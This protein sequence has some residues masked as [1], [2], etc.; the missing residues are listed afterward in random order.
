MTLEDRVEA[1]EA[2]LGTLITNLLE[3]ALVG[4]FVTFG[5]GAI[6]H[7]NN[8]GIQFRTTGRAAP[9]VEPAIWFTDRPGPDTPPY[10]RAMVGGYGN[11]TAPSPSNRYA[12]TQLL[13]ALSEESYAGIGT[14]A[15]EGDAFA[16]GGIEV[17][18]T[19]G[20]TTWSA[21]LNLLATIG[22]GS[23]RA[24]GAPFV[25]P[26][27]EGDFANL[28]ARD[29]SLQYDSDAHKGRIVIA[30]TAE[31]IATEGYVTGAIPAVPSPGAVGGQVDIGDGASDGAASSYARSDHQHAVPAPGANYPQPVGTALSD[32][33]A[34]T[35]ARSDHVHA[36]EAAHIHHDT[37]WAAKG[38]LIVGTANDT[39]QVLSVGTN[40]HVLTADSAQATGTKWA[41]APVALVFVIDG[42]GSAIATG[43]KGYIEV[44]FAMTITGWTLVAKESGSI[45]IDVWKDTYANFPPTVADTIAGTE[46]PTLSSA[47]KNQDTSL[48][49]WTTAVA[50]G[51][52]L[53]FDVSS[54]TTVTQVTLTIRGTRP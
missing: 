3:P 41:A 12:A 24:E 22:G 15:G 40:G 50:A 28:T 10:P 26:D 47:Q 2:T 18:Y 19:S 36:H 4:P 6:G 9:E 16:A 21:A 54:A 51:D 43:V 42:G 25:L 48:S 32:G 13:S 14:M 29:G 38:D 45:V 44:P 53:G 8:T 11:G 30:G 20:P 34:T 17:A 5:D 49:T 39:A 52:V 23:I 46:K 27:A 1:I 31:N 35:P 33:T 37:T 7:L